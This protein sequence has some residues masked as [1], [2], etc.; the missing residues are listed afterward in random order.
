MIFKNKTFFLCLLILMV[1]GGCGLYSNTSATKEKKRALCFEKSLRP[2]NEIYLSNEKW[3]VFNGDDPTQ[4]AD[5]LIAKR[6][7]ILRTGGTVWGKA[8][9]GAWRKMEQTEL[10]KEVWIVK[11]TSLFKQ[12]D[13]RYVTAYE[14]RST[15]SMEWVSTLCPEEIAAIQLDVCNRLIQLGFSNNCDESEL[16]KGLK[17]YQHKYQLPVGNYDLKTM[18]EMGFWK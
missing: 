1:V 2:V 8:N 12:F 9:N 7:V 15:P 11:D 16:L 6:K 17:A 13:F 14:S 10:A 18:K 4:M 5:S 3:P